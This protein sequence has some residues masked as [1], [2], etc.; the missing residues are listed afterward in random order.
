MI[1]FQFILNKLMLFFI[2]L[3]IIQLV[4]IYS[5][6]PMRKNFIKLINFINFISF[7]QKKI[8]ISRPCTLSAVHL[9]NRC[10][11]CSECSAPCSAADGD[12]ATPVHSI[13]LCLLAAFTVAALLL[14]SNRCPLPQASGSESDGGRRHEHRQGRVRHRSLR[15]HCFLA[16][17]VPSAAWL[18]CT[19]HRPRP[20]SVFDCNSDLSY[21][22]FQI[23]HSSMECPWLFFFHSS[24]RSPEKGIIF[25]ISALGPILWNC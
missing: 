21:Q 10:Q 12:H 2:G 19:R 3:Y 9:P 15:L 1:F 17:Q 23:I 18:H 16:C 4:D 24:V 7:K 25:V 6:F 13:W 11:N 8:F 14:R 22:C 5:I 20:W